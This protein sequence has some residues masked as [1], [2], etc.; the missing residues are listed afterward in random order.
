MA[1]T[2]RKFYNT[3]E[4]KGF[5]KAVFF[6]TVLAIVNGEEVEEDLVDLVGAAAEYELEGISLRAENKGSTEK[7]DPLDSGYAV[8]LRAAIIPLLDA[9]PRT[10]QEL[11]DAATAKGK[12]SPKGTKFAPPWVSRV[13]NKA[14]GVSAV[15]KVIEKVD[16]KGLT[17]QV[18]VTAYIA[19]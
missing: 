9:T 16:A 2:K 11:I 17:S 5:T 15:K 6:E 19:K 4:A 14:D 7:K 8:A 10:A 13:L 1:D 18:E 3:G 12:L